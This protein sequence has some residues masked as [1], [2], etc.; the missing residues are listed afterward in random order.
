MFLDRPLVGC[1][2]GQY[3]DQCV[4]YLHDPSTDL[5]LETAR[6]YVQHNVWLALLTETGLVGA[7]LFSILLWLWTAHAWRLWHSS[8]AP[9]WAR[10]Q[11]LLWL[12]LLGMYIPCAMFHNVSL[13]PMVNMLMF[14]LAGL[15]MGLRPPTAELNKL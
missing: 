11:G 6:R 14:F 9:P 12:A 4:D 5:P 8:T 1:G 2:L 13:I 10:R 15:T 3:S 7:G